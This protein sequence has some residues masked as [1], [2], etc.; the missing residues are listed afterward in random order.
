MSRSVFAL[1]FCLFIALTFHRDILM[2][3]MYHD[4][5]LP[6]LKITMALSTHASPRFAGSIM[7]ARFFVFCVS[8]V[9]K[10]RDHLELAGLF[11]SCSIRM[12]GKRGHIPRGHCLVCLLPLAA[13][14]VSYFCCAHSHLTTKSSVPVL[15]SFV[16][17]CT[18]GG[19]RFLSPGRLGEAP[20]RILLCELQCT[21]N[22]V[23]HIFRP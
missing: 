16:D 5:S 14:C 21:F 19:C 6:C 15:L 2:P 17:L 13:V 18:P 20:S 7:N 8:R 4:A 11:L 1:L 3:P 22:H 23:Q 12:G 9:G 10:W